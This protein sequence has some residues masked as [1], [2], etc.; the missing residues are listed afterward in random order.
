[1]KSLI[2]STLLGVSLCTLSALAA[3]EPPADALRTL[4]VRYGDVDLTHIDGAIALYQRLHRAARDVCAPP[5]TS[6]R[7][8]AGLT[9]SCEQYAIAQAVAEVNAPLLT[10]YFLGKSG[11]VSPALARR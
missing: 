3:A 4:T 5:V 8:A 9:R 6:D 2:R 10:S 7:I 1:M 11:A